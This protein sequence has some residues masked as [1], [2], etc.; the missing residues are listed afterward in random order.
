MYLEPPE[1]D[2][3]MRLCIGVDQILEDKLTP[4]Q[5]LQM[6][7]AGEL[8]TMLLLDGVPQTCNFDETAYHEMLTHV[9]LLTHP[10]P[11]DVLVVGGGDG[12]I[13]RETLRH[14]GVDRVV[15]C[16]IDEEV[17]RASKQHLP[18]IAHGLKDERVDV[19]ILDAVEFMRDSKG[20]W[21]AVIVD[22]SDPIGPAK[23]LF[24]RPF[25]EDVRQALRPG[26]VVAA[27]MESFFLYGDL[28]SGVFAFMGEMFD[29]AHYYT[30]NVPT[31]SSGVI[32]MAL[33]SLGPDPLAGPDPERVE[34]LGDLDYYNAATH[35]ASFALPQRALRLLPD[36]I[37]QR[38]SSVFDN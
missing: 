32:G 29:Y 21:D 26:G 27:Q 35:K 33:C 10:D 19:R 3:A 5:R 20:Q 18:E 13:V 25:Y 11:K 4:Y 2:G 30:T 9:P 31:Y 6:V 14:P 8:G 1:L 17:V 16:E 36:E 22:S 24:G 15:L 7:D 23:A 34:A 12:G 28:I 37:A 38:Q